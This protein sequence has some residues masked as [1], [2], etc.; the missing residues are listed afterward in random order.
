LFKKILGSIAL[1]AIAATVAVAP[2]YAANSQGGGQTLVLNPGG[3]RSLVGDDG[4]AMVFNGVVLGNGFTSADSE[5][6]DVY[7]SQTGSDQAYFAGVS[8]W[9]CWSGVAP[10][11]NIGGTLYGD[12]SAAAGFN[13]VGGSTSWNSVTVTASTGA[14]EIIANGS[15]AA[16]SSTAK[17]DATA[18]IVYSVTHNSRTFTVERDITY[19]NPDTWYDETWTI[20]IPAGNT[21]TVKFYLGGDASPGWTDYGVGESLTVDGNIHLRELNPDSGQYVSYQERGTTFFDH[22]FIGDFDAPYEIMQ[23]GDN[24]PDTIDTNADDPH[25]AGIQIQWTFGSTPGDYSRDMRTRFGFINGPP[26]LGGED[27]APTGANDGANALALLA[28]AGIV[29]AVAVRRRAR[30]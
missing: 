15:D 2:S 1:A 22:Y 7:V 9:C 28:I 26:D 5:V 12:M 14:K 8:Q 6:G 20:T 10:V 30:V 11:L 4:I 19:N 23:A 29:A 17:G 16:I 21:E 18:T 24:L 13:G 25:D 27:L 3:G